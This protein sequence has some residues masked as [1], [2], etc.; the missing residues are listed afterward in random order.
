MAQ[1]RINIGRLYRVSKDFAKSKEELELALDY[2]LEN[3]DD[4][5]LGLIYQNLNS[6]YIDSKADGEKVKSTF[7]KA[8]FYYQKLEYQ[9]GI[10]ELFNNQGEYFRKT[11]QLDSARIYIEKALQFNKTH[12]TH[13]NDA[14]LL[15]D[16]AHLQFDKANYKNALQFAQESYNIALEKNLIRQQINAL[17]LISKIGLNQN[18]T[19]AVYDALT[20]INGLQDSLFRKE[21]TE[22]F[23]EMSVLFDVKNK[24]ITIEKQQ[25]EI[26]NRKFRESFLWLSTAFLALAF[27]ALLY[28]LRFRHNKLRQLYEKNIELLKEHEKNLHFSSE[29]RSSIIIEKDENSSELLFKRLENIMQE[30]K[31]YKNSQLIF[32]DLV[33][34]LSTN[35]KYLSNTINRFFGSNF[36]DYINSYRVA[37]AQRLIISHQSLTMEQI[38]H[39][40]GFRS[41]STFSTAFKKFSGMT[42]GE[43]RKM[44][45]EKAGE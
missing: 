30:E 14:Q 4:Y 17:H 38:M 26:R 18:N 22:S 19:Q 21:K 9:R 1:T 23:A 42:P 24:N 15:L 3:K 16:L 35:Q 10:T 37:E 39:Q 34:K 27:M 45:N 20:E 13:Q 33:N 41:R 29:N 5:F 12:D 43:F 11:D 6:L 25:L 32:E 8:L 31:P 40:C 7:R 36:N 2:F 44:D 28:F